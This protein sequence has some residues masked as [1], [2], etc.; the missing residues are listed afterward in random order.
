MSMREAAV[1][2]LFYEADPARLKAQVAGFLSSSLPQ[3]IARPKVL[4]VPHAGYVYSGSTAASAYSLLEP[5]RDQIRR[6]V[7]LGPAHRVYLQGMALPSVDAFVTPLGEVPLERA[8]LDAISAMPGV[9]VSDEAHREEHSL[10]VQLPFLQ[11][12]LTRFSLLPVVVGDCDPQKVGAV[13]DELWGGPETLVVISSDLSHFH[14]YDEACEIDGSTCARILQ[15]S[16]GLSGE[17]ACGARALNGLMSAR[18][19]QDM[20]VDLLAACNSG[21]TAGNRERVVGYGAFQLY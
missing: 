17:E 1:A 14:P 20:S 18:H 4:I 8:A 3:A 9:C 5:L 13:L 12:L 7:L 21:D 2:G 10:E 16:T 15:K 19:C 11:T 6:V